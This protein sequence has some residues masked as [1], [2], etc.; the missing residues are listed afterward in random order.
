MIKLRAIWDAVRVHLKAVWD[1]KR[2]REIIL[3]SAAGAIILASFVVKDVYRDE[4]KEKLAG[5]TAAMAAYQGAGEL[6]TIHTDI[7]D[8]KD[9][10]LKPNKEKPAGDDWELVANFAGIYAKEIS[11]LES[12]IPRLE[13]LADSLDL[14]TGEYSFK[15]D[16]VD[17][18][19][20]Y[21]E[22]REALGRIITAAISHGQK[23]VK[24]L[25]AL[26][27]SESDV[28]TASQTLDKQFADL[29]GS[30]IARQFDE[31][32]SCKITLLWSQPLSYLLFV[33]GWALALYGKI[34]HVPGLDAGEET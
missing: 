18:Q 10:V 13:I 24:D 30:I 12:M 6:Q 15:R 33:A 19:M 8:L 29:S 26:S 16:L 28:V 34:L 27:S 4:A 1:D 9:T 25:E 11:A 17:L 3:V 20:S 14:A 22:K 21:K 32:T 31:T 7:A 5:L 2:Q 23:S